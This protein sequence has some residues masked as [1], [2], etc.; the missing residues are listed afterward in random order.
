MS[1]KILL[2]I[3][4]TIFLT[5]CTKEKLYVSE[6][7]SEKIILNAQ[8]YLSDTS[9]IVFSGISAVGT[10]MKLP[11]ARIECYVN[12][13]AV[14]NA[15]FKLDTIGFSLQSKYKF[16]AKF[17][18]G[19]VVR[20]SVSREKETAYSEVTVPGVGGV[21]SQVDTTSDGD[22]MIFTSKINDNSFGRNYYRLR[23]LHY[24]TAWLFNDIGV[25]LGR[26]SGSVNVPLGNDKDPI[27]N[28]NKPGGD[29]EEYFTSTH[30]NKYCVFSD[31]L[32]NGNNCYVRVKAS[33]DQLYSLSI[34]E[35][36][37]SVITR[38]YAVLSLVSI[39]KEEYDYLNGLN[40]LEDTGYDSEDWLEQLTI[41]NNVVGGLGFVSISSENRLSIRLKDLSF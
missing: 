6:D 5:F 36:Y 13:K 35:Y 29:Q 26:V 10:V 9:H 11:D 23:L 31:R 2:L 25:P 27:L 30:P 32:F 3:I 28:G 4:S 14:G 15:D 1:K 24:Y 16:N 41:E 39:T 19:D 22:N 34:N 8:I 37:H 18:P 21:I 40:T 17:K 7:Q 20:I 33:V 12:G 38:N